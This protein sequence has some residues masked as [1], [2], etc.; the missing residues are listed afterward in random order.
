M[1]NDSIEIEKSLAR[2]ENQTKGKVVAIVTPD[3]NVFAS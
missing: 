1:A 3:G 2:G